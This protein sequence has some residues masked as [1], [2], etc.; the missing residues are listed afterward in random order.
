L[1]LLSLRGPGRW[2]G[3]RYCRLFVPA[4]AIVVVL[5]GVAATWQ[6]MIAHFYWTSGV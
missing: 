1:L 4:M 6:T 2:A 3:N 5:I